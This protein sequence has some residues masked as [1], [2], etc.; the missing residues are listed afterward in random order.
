MQWK[1]I[2][3]QLE[4]TG[5]T[6]KRAAELLAD[7]FGTQMRYSFDGDQYTVADALDRAWTV[8][9]VAGLRAEK[10]LNDRLVGANQLYHVKICSPLL[11]QQDVDT[12]GDILHRLE[13]G[14][15]I[16][17]DTTRLTVL[18]G[19]ANLENKEKYVTNLENIYA[20]KGRLLQKALH[21]E[22]DA[23]ADCSELEDKG[24][25]SFPIF[26]SSFNKN[27]VQSCIQLAQV[28]SRLATN[29][30]RISRKENP[31]QNEKFLL[32]TWLVHIGFVGWEY[33]FARKMLTE[34][35]EGNSAWLRKTNQ[36][37][38]QQDSL[39]GAGTEAQIAH[40]ESSPVEQESETQQA[41][42]SAT[43]HSAE[44]LQD[45]LSS[46]EHEMKT[47]QGQEEVRASEQADALRQEKP[48]GMTM[49]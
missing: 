10:M 28:V 35:L 3:V 46:L 34:G 24:L 16:L 17:N 22:F 40:E 42:L 21:R 48:A 32:R 4:L 14:G 36:T 45:D 12:L 19:V 37:E 7:Y 5:M 29:G 20:S 6:R 31:S 49:K 15:G 30:K 47:R 2:A 18:L 23:L 39:S 8:T 41:E 27:E 11:Y 9:P 44:I 25:V 43:P 33:K 13:L 38:V 1:K 26:R